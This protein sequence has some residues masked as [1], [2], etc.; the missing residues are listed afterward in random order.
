MSKTTRRL[1][2]FRFSNFNEKARW[3]LAYKGVDLPRTDY[4]PGPHGGQIKKI[5]PL[6]HTPILEWDGTYVQGSAEVIDFL[7]KAYPEPALYPADPT[8][9]EQALAL[10][11]HFDA[12]AGPEARR[13]LFLD[14][15]GDA[16]YMAGLFAE[17]KPWLVRKSYGAMLPLVRPIMRSAMDLTM[18]KQT[19]AL[20]ATEE[21]LDFVAEASKETGYLV[22]DTFSVAD[23]AAAALLSITANPDH[24]DM[25]RPEPMSKTT[26]A[27]LDRWEDHSGTAW[28]RDIYSKHRPA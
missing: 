15:M 26:R 10:Q 19:A 27:W 20:K 21:A 24:P 7:E 8:Q 14:T 9:R 13:A 12:T 25:K 3:A 4:L 18:D 17:G 1:H 22:G 23:L 6:S 16:K 5:A 2:Q 28:I 11:A